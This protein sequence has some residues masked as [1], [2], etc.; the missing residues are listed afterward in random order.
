MSTDRLKAYASFDSTADK[1]NWDDQFE[2]DLTVRSPLRMADTDPLQTIR[3]Y[4]AKGLEKE[5]PSAPAPAPA[6]AP[7]SL[8][9]P[10]R[11][12]PQ[13]SRNRASSPMKPPVSRPAFVLPVRSTSIFREE[14]T[15]DY[16]DLIATSDSAFERKLGILA[17]C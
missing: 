1:E 3:P 17:V 11:P 5:E 12:P 10:Q 2:G 7:P 4:S 8:Y 14:S 9:S 13:P 15:E 16:S 6:P